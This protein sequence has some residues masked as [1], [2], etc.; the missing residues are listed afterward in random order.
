MVFE[1]AQ[2]YHVE[3]RADEAIRVCNQVMKADPTNAEAAALLGDIYAEQDR[4]DVALAMYEKAMRL[5]PN[6]L[7]YRQKWDK[8]G[9]ARETRYGSGIGSPWWRKPLCQTT[10]SRL[11]E[12]T[13]GHRRDQLR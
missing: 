7:L 4:K 10:T 13:S 3:G 8:C 12:R 11:A 6:N 2:L 5:Q 1:A 9:T